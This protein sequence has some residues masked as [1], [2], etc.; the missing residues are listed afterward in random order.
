MRHPQKIL[1]SKNAT[2][3]DAMKL[4]NRRLEKLLIVTNNKKFYGVI[5]DGDLRR[6]ILNG[7]SLSQKIDFIVNK[8]PLT[9]SDQLSDKEAYDKINSKILVLPVLNLKNEIKGYYSYKDK[10]Q[11]FS[12]K[13]K[14]VL[15]FGMGY[16][17]LT[18]GAT[19]SNLGFTVIGYD[20]DKKIISNLKKGKPPFFEKGLKKY[21]DPKVNLNLTFTN[22]LN[23]NVASTYI[24]AVGSPINKRT[25][26]PDIQ[27]VISFSKE[28]AKI[29]KKN[30]LIIMRSTLPIGTTRKIV[31]PILENKSKFKAGRD[32]HIVCAPE[33]TAEGKAMQELKENP[34]IIGCINQISFQKA[35]DLFSTFTKSI[36]PLPSLESAEFSKLLDN[37]YRDSIFAFINQMVPIAEKLKIDLCEVVEAVNHGY[38]RN[39]IPKP[40]P[41][42][43]GPCLVKDSYLLKYNFDNLK[44]GNKL[45]DSSRKVNEK[46]IVFLYSKI[47]K[48]LKKIGK[49]I[50]NSKIFIIGL[51]FK[52]NPE[53]SDLRDSTSIDLINKIKNKKNLYVYDPVI[54]KRVINNLGYKYQTLEKGF[55]KSD[56]VIFL[57][58]HKSYQELNI[59]HLIK[60]MNKP[61]I[62]ID[63]WKI[64]NPIEIKNIK[65]VLYGGLGFD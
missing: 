35:S 42:V 60:K 22:K 55:S 33:R 62:I 48:L 53:T 45:L 12:L 54:D 59:F 13:S 43:G 8:N 5:N 21:I 10:N 3:R 9:V 18:L 36:I 23:N 25:K 50:N 29:L 64:F 47:N 19:I 49:N 40:S 51:A 14:K 37:T 27:S 52:G 31:I 16:V 65:N 26:K 15:V 61:G 1:I 63:T 17:G 7:S 57:N 4:L 58:N 11:L 24:C 6:A 39:N 46:T 34:Q 30:D 41:G 56:M 28:I 44:I 2:I 38:S 20:K 32:F